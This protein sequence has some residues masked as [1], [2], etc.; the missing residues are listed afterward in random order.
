M[1]KLDF[2]TINKTSAKSFN[3]QRNLIKRIGK[4]ET[5]LCAT[6]KQPLTLSVASS[7]EPGISC[8]KGCT[9]ISLEL[10]E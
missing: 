8:K 5:V 2:S 10:E 1:A 4:G 7:G 9:H 6:C 3:E